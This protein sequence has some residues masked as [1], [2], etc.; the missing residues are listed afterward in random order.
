VIGFYSLFY[1]EPTARRIVRVCTSPTCA[2]DGAHHT[3]ERM[4]QH[5][6][7]NAGQPTDDGETLLE[8]TE[9]LGLCDQ[10]PA[11]LVSTQGQGESL[12]AKVYDGA[13]SETTHKHSPIKTFFVL[14]LAS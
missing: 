13:R 7:V 1:N 9:C 6:K 2:I 11:V 10:S 14:T 12:H 8:A 4:C 3:L 5:L